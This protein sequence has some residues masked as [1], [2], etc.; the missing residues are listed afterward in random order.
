[1][2]RTAE[3]AP[4]VV[5]IAAPALNNLSEV[6]V[7]S[8]RF[9]LTLNVHSSGCLVLCVGVLRF[10]FFVVKSNRNKIQKQFY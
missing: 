7:V 8:I 5:F 2:L 4:F 9:I 10:Q 3:F 6:S 1:M